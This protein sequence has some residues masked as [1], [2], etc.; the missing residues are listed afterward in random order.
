M[1]RNN[2]PEPCRACHTHEP[3]FSCSCPRIVRC[4]TQQTTAR[5]QAAVRAAAMLLCTSLTLNLHRRRESRQT[6][7]AP[8]VLMDSRQISSAVSTALRV[9]RSV[10]GW[11]G[12]GTPRVRRTCSF[13]PE[14][15]H[16]IDLC[17]SVQQHSPVQLP[18]HR[19][20]M[21]VMRGL[22]PPM[23][24]RDS[25]SKQVRQTTK[26]FFGRYDRPNGVELSRSFLPTWLSSQV[27]GLCSRYGRV[28]E[29]PT[30]A[31][32]SEESGIDSFL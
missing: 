8:G 16:Q 18:G 13:T 4:R 31:A 3:S 19:L 20:Q 22:V 9:K 7:M 23:P 29:N 32:R 17:C 30:C 2:D 28:E 1:K 5:L 21:L 10:A 12:M 24:V 6:R 26:E 14:R 15:C 27:Q 25:M 11:R